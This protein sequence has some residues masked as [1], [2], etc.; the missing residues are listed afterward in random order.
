P[1]SGLGV[2][3]FPYFGFALLAPIPAMLYLIR[4]LKRHSLFFPIKMD[5]AWYH[6]AAHTSYFQFLSVRNWINRPS[7]YLVAAI[8]IIGLYALLALWHQNP[9]FLIDTFRESQDFL[10]SNHRNW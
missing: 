10:F 2:A 8:L 4:E 3:V 7:Y 5:G 9:W 1:L 6:P